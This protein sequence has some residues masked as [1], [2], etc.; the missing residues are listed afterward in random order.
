MSVQAEAKSAVGKVIKPIIA[1]DN[2]PILAV[3]VLFIV[4]VTMIQP[5]FLM[6]MNLRNILIQVSIVGIAALAQTM[7]MISGGIDLSVGWNMSFLGCL[8]AYLMVAVGL[9]I[10]AVVGLTILV[11]IMFAGVMGFIISRTR[12][13]PF[14]ISL[15]FMIIYQGFTYLITRGSEI[16]IGRQFMLLGRTFPFGIGMPVYIFL[17]L[18]LVFALTLRFTRFG[19]RIY[20]VG[21]NQEAAFLS[22]VNVKNFKLSVYVISGVLVSLAALTQLSRLGTGNPLMGG[23]REIDVIASVVVGGTAL[24]GGKGNIWGTVVGVILLGSIKNAMNVIG[25]SPHWQFVFI[26]TVIILSVVISYYGG[27]GR[28]PKKA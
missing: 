1:H 11:A 19:R 8:G 17:G 23:G 26:G 24:S 6:P 4:V 9:P 25:I 21:S 7:V 5:R 2:A 22:G 20:A 12:I 14:I 3:F 16:G 18:A 13:E 10:P 28:S 27:I 15:G